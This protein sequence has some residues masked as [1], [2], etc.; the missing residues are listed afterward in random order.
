MGKHQPR[1]VPFDLCSKSFAAP[2]FTA[3]LAAQHLKSRKVNSSYTAAASRR[4]LA[5]PLSLTVQ[6]SLGSLAREQEDTLH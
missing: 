4:M 3:H 5:T 1:V 6:S 2:R